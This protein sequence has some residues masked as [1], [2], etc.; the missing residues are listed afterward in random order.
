MN[1]PFI[2]NM[3]HTSRL[4]KVF[5]ISLCAV[6]FGASSALQAMNESRLKKIGAFNI[7]G[8][9]DPSNVILKKVTPKAVTKDT[10]N[11]KGATI[12]HEAKIVE[13]QS[14]TNVNVSKKVSVLERVKALE[15][16]KNLGTDFIENGIKIDK[17]NADKE[18]KPIIVT[19]ASGISSIIIKGVAY[20]SLSLAL[21]IYIYYTFFWR[22]AI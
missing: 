18:I 6:S 21:A 14:E 11:S 7:F 22:A 9:F 10:K 19:N 2:S 17:N 1:K 20:T 5:F 15:K 4:L 3:S 12:T 8:D 13:K 16:S